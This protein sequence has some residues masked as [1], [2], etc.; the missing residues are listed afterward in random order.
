LPQFGDIFLIGSYPQSNYHALQSTFKRNLSKGLQF[1]F[2]YTWAHTIDDVVGFFKD[3]QDE[4][5]T[6]GERA[7]SDQDIRHNFVFD[8]SYELPFRSVWSNGPKW[9]TDGWQLSTISQ[10]RTALPVNVT[11]QGGIF[12]GFSFRPNLVPG[13]DP[14]APH[15]GRCSGGFRVPD[16]QYNELAF[17]D[18]GNNLPGNTPRNFLRGRPFAQVDLSV[19]KNTRLSENMALQ[20]RMDV[21][22]L[23]NLVNFADPSAGLAIGD[24]PNTL[25]PTAFFGRSVSTVGNQ[26]GGL[27]GFG[28]PRQVQLSARFSF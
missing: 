19:S 12:G 10:F 18:P 28:G 11:R 15:S 20:L 22:N 24:T 16:C 25:R 17:S 13:E 26:L 6:K 27:L 2:N 5:N 8:A 3:Y 9:I 7:S 14:N 1:N 4:Y 23:F 21:F